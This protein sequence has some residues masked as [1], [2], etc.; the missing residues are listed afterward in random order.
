MTVPNAFAKPSLM[1]KTTLTNLSALWLTASVTLFAPI[2]LQAATQYVILDPNLSW[3][4]FENV[5]TNGVEATINPPY[6]ADYVGA[7]LSLPLQATMDDQGTVTIA[8][9][10][11]MDQLFPTDTLIWADASGSSAGICKVIST[12]YAE[13]TTFGS[14]DT[15][16]FTGSLQTNGLAAPYTNT[17]VVFIKDFDSGWGFRGKTTVN[18]NT[19]TNGQPFAVT[20]TVGGAGDHV[21]W[22]IEWGGPPAR[23]A[24]VANFGTA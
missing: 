16:I 12:F 22:G 19:L 9:D 4:G 14:G 6:K 1:I 3:N 17:A 5:F 7:G 20:S 13:S 21:Q 10:I 23:V 8:P 18:L 15:V 2:G 11:R 24:T